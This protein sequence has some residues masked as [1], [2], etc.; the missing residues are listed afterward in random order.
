MTNYKSIHFTVDFEPEEKVLD[1]VN[2]YLAKQ[3]EPRPFVEP[4]AAGYVFRSHT[5]ED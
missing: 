4:N 1:V 2:D 5:L 3:P